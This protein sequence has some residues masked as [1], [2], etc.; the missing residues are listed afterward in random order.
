MHTRPRTIVAL[1]RAD[2]VSGINATARRMS[3]LTEPW[4]ALVCGP[5]HDPGARTLPGFGDLPVSIATWASGADPVTQS[6]AVL[7][8]LRAMGATIVVPNDIPHGF[9]AAGLDQGRDHG[10]GLRAAAWI[11]A[12]GLDAEELVERCGGLAST[13]RG[14]SASNARRASAVGTLPSL[15][16]AELAPCPVDVAER[17]PAPPALTA[18][19][20]IELLY[21]GRLERP[22]KR[23][24]D[25]VVLCNALV[26]VGV[27]FHLRVAGR[28]PAE[29]ELAERL[30]PHVRCGR[31][32]MLGP[33]P[34]DQMGDLYAS[35]HA[36]V[37]VSASEGTPVVAME[38]M[39][40]A[41]PVIA[42]DGAGGVVGP[43]VANACG[44][45]TPIGDMHAM[46]HAIASLTPEALR[47]MGAR[48]HALA[49]ETYSTRAL[50]PVIGRWMD[51]TEAAPIAIDPSDPT[52][53]A[54]RWAMILRALGAIGPCPESAIRALSTRYLSTLGRPQ[55]A[56]GLATWLPD[57]PG[58]RER[59]FTRI[60]DLIVARGHGRVAL[61]GAG[62]HTA[63]LERAIGVRPEVI[64]IADDRA[65]APGSP[66]SVAGRSVVLPS[67]LDA[68]GVDAVLISSDEHEQGMLRRA[69]E[70]SG[71]G[72]C[73]ARVFPLY[74]LRPTI[75]YSP[76]R[77]M[78]DQA[79]GVPRP[80]IAFDSL[81]VQATRRAG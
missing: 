22:H 71:A 65:H 32:T 81:T 70:W 43:I 33:V 55:M 13:W 66:G 21:A 45:I 11:H 16:S 10:S 2:H 4:R 72:M 64:A 24:M 75:G 36:L 39:A 54:A 48:A 40:A 56:G 76:T 29:S 50:E 69:L 35:V 26:A 28:G 37:L 34:A 52:S 6:L 78:L 38:A 77:A 20:P 62:S 3:M 15:R 57:L 80:P 42:T 17:S 19:A 14:V 7:D 79:P 47:V 41:R 51:E 53:I 12:D 18:G 25:L 60:L 68:L 67:E 58:P 73:R 44:T 74:N 63:A 31:A 61:Y 5:G 27:P 1:Y 8:A 9:V 46:A 59:H 49:R 23:V 30:A